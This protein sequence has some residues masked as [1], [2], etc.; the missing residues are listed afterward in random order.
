MPKPEPVIILT[1][2]AA[3]AREFA[4]LLGAEAAVILS[5]VL[6]IQ[7]LPARIE[8]DRFASFVFTSQNAVRAVDTV[9]DLAGKHVYAVGERTAKIAADRGARVTVAGGTAEKL[10][11]TI[12]ADAPTG[13][14][15]FLRGKHTTG[16]LAESLNSVGI[17]T[18]ESIVYEQNAKKMTKAA[19]SAL[20]GEG[21]V[22]L[23]LFS[24]RTATILSDMVAQHPIGASLTLICLSSAVAKAWAGPTPK[25]VFV[26][27]QPTAA[28]MA[29]N[30]LRHIGRVA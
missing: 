24:V 10:V 9:L 14:L 27:D 4:A 25:A 22:V 23:P 1:R 5:P 28:E 11:D 30:I 16:D 26:A 21:D 7:T 13:R 6:E 8:A 3:A 20:K 29:R 2:P 17:V 15:L 19:V 12:R 18:E